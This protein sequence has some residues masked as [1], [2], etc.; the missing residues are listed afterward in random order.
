MIDVGNDNNGGGIEDN[1][2][3]RGRTEPTL[4]LL[5]DSY[6]NDEISVSDGRPSSY[7]AY[8]FY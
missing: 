3:Y 4:V 2:M 8:M 6:P 1:N 7:P 5:S